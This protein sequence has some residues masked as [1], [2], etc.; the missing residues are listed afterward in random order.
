MPDNIEQRVLEFVW[1]QSPD[2]AVESGFLPPRL[3][4]DM[5]LGT[6]ARVFEQADDLDRT[7]AQANLTAIEKLAAQYHLYC[8]KFAADMPSVCRLNHMTGVVGRLGWAAWSWPLAADPSC[9]IY[10]ERLEQFSTYCDALLSRI[11]EE[12]ETP[13]Y[14]S[15][16]V[17]SAF[18]A[19]IDAFV[20]AE[21]GGSGTLL[22]PLMTA[23]ARGATVKSPRPD[24]LDGVLGSALALRR[25]AE[26]LAWSANDFSPLS[27]VEDGRKRYCAAI[28]YGASTDITPEEIERLGRAAL[29]NTDRRFQVLSESG[30]VDMACPATAEELMDSFRAAYAQIIGALPLITP[31]QPVME[32]R[33][34]P[35]P[36]EHAVAGPPAFYGP[37]S[38][39]NARPGSLYVNTTRPIRTRTWEVLPLTIHEGMPG[40]HFQLALLDENQDLSVLLRELSVNAFT[41][42]W[43]VYAETLAPEMGLSTSPT[44]EFGLL[45]YQ[46]WRAARLVVDVGL[47]V[48][49]WS[50]DEATRFM[51][52]KTGQDPGHVRREV[53]R[54]LA[55]PG[56]ALGYSIGAQVIA[57]WIKVRRSR[58][59]SLAASHKELVSMGSVP[60]SA[61]SS[62]VDT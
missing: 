40:H 56:Q 26:N 62:A 24:V 9:D 39:R 4:E 10:V 18:I 3:W 1:E 7:I 33:I 13:Q 44:A 38:L 12:P 20:D 51:V 27:H 47:H 34:V 8:A 55:W 17:L 21:R 50:V 16:A 58:G 41:E 43:A 59:I 23:R 57:D 22:L 15:K 28:H 53:V 32:C 45:A 30:S 19:Q 11:Q 5:S 49:G 37:S 6:K 60:L 29:S 36:D 14:S 35:M 25:A 46:R 52:D 61:L 48:H 42:G 31:V 54:Y 2:Q